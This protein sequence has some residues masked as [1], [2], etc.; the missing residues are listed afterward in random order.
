[1]SGL[2][3]ARICVEGWFREIRTMSGI[4]GNRLVVQNAKEEEEEEEREPTE[5][6][7]GG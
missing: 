3:T 6:G 5:E 2:E 1:M 4:G 7:F